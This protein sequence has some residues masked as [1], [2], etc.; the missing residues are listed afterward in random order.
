MSTLKF[1][2]FVITAED[3]VESEG[4]ASFHIEL[5]M[6]E[7]GPIVVADVG[8]L[9]E[10]VIGYGVLIS[11]FLCTQFFL[12]EV[13]IED[14][15]CTEKVGEVFWLTGLCADEVFGEKCFFFFDHKCDE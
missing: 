8:I 9:H 5:C 4:Q 13:G 1:I 10:V 12:E 11:P 7:S 6:V 14:D 3:A 2:A 15:S